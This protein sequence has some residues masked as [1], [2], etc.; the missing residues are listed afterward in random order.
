[1]SQQFHKYHGAGNDFIIID[2]RQKP[3]KPDSNVIEG[4]C[5]RKFGI[6]ADGL[7][8]LEKSAEADFYMRYFNSDGKESTMCGNGGRCI[9]AFARD[10]GIIDRNTQFLASDGE[11]KALIKEDNLI[12]LKMQDVER[13]KIFD[14][15]FFVDTGSPHYVRFVDNLSKV[16]V[17]EEGKKIRYNTGISETG[18]NVNFVSFEKEGLISIRTYERGVENETLACGTGAVAS[19]ISACL[20]SHTDKNSYTVNAMGGRLHV[21]FEPAGGNRFTNV[22]LTGPAEYVFEG[23]FP[24]DSLI[25]KDDK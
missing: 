9:V 15:H 6:G 1:M 22:W 2:N 18:T 23:S 21:S 16:P 3:F 7:M 5:R 10:L 25:K 4:L 13:V 19:A 8:L 20:H 11:H 24:R 12:A 17:Y 14:D